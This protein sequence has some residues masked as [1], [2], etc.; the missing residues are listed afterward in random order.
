MPWRRETAPKPR[1]SPKPDPV[2]PTLLAWA[3][4]LDA[5]LLSDKTAKDAEA[6]LRDY[7]RMPLYARRE[8]ALRLRAAIEDQITPIPPPTIGSMDVIATVL[9]ARRSRLG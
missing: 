7:R 8:I 5:T 6:F 9:S 1:P 3:N 2:S 4:A